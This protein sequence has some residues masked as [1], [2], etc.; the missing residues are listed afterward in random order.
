M[1]RNCGLAVLVALG[2]HLAIYTESCAGQDP[3]QAIT[4]YLTSKR[5]D[6]MPPC[7]DP[8][9]DAPATMPCADDSGRKIR[10]FW[11]SR[12]RM[13]LSPAGGIEEAE[14]PQPP[15]DCREDPTSPYQYP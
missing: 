12:Q 2:G 11:K 1:P 14:P 13:P 8:G 10:D 15:A 4:R 9:Q 7:V 5:L 6:W 3:G